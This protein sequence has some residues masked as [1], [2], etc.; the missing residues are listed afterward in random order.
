MSERVTNEKKNLTR[1]A[2]EFLVAS[3][4][5]ER[6]YM[7]SLQWGATIGFDLLVFDKSGR[8]AFLEVKCSA[9]NPRRWALQKKYAH[10]EKDDI[11]VPKRF[12]CCVDISDTGA[13][14]TVFVFPAE[15][16]AK[17][18]YYLYDGRFSKSPTYKFDLDGKPRGHSKD[19]NARTL[20]QFIDASKYIDRY[21]ALGV[22]KV[23][24]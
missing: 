1:L 4:L 16:V 24:Q 9:S 13:A 20:A 7:V 10:P 19:P 17:G 21:A 5:S 11:L 2:G 8:E 6:G 23:S 3:R 14:P 22:G 12:V 15:V 18:L